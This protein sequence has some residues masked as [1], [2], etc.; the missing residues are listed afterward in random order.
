MR[1]QARTQALL[2]V[3][4][5]ALLAGTIPVNAHP[6][7]DFGGDHRDALKG[8]TYTGLVS[9]PSPGGVP[10]EAM[11]DIRCEDGMAGIFPCHRVDLAAFLPLS[12]V[13]AT[14][15]NDVWGWQDPVTG[16]QLAI[17]GTFEGTAFVDVTDGSAPVYLGTLESQVPG[18][19]GNIWGDIRV[20]ADTAYIGAEAL[21]F[22]TYDP[23]AGTIEGFGVQVVDLTQFRGATEPIDDIQLTHHI[24]H[25]SQSH[26]LSINED[27]GRLY[28]VGSYAGLAAAVSECHTESPDGLPVLNGSGGALIYDLTG[29]PHHPEFIGCVTTD[30]YNHDIQCVVYRGPDPDYQ[31]KEVCIG[32][33]EVSV[34][35]YDVTDGS[36]PVEV[37]RI[38]YL[39]VPPD[40]EQPSPPFY[41]HQGWLT[42]DQRYFFLSDE[43]DELSGLSTERATYIW[44][45]ADLDDPQLIGV[46]TDGNTS[47]DHNLFVHDGLLYQANYTS[48]LW[49]YDSWKVE[50]GRVVMRGFFDVFP[51][52]DRTDFFGSWGN[53]P[54]FGDGKVVVTSSDEG[55]FVLQSRATSASKDVDKSRG[56]GRG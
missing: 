14:F 41:T 17:V 37:S 53:Y 1:R 19:F 23:A 51:A 21:D 8:R 52:D 44:D 4:V 54:F 15:V 7:H 12:D 16:M 28:V 48:G 38:G 27:T 22:T 46:H 32:S 49:I 6:V 55:L 25:V 13:E 5:L 31:D 42:A 11:F 20:Y 36:S 2:A 10:M 3:T 40:W 34:G 26:N 29:D 47:I 35:I 56:N 33:D 30:V 18:D 45:L 9:D 24:D 50:Q 39:D 43:L